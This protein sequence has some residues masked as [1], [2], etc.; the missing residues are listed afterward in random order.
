[1]TAPPGRHDLEADITF[2]AT[3]AGGKS[4]AARSGYRPGNDFGLRGMHNDAH[5]EFVEVDAVAPGQT[6]RARLWLLAPEYQA[7]RLHPGFE[8][9]VHE[10]TRLVARGVIVEVVNPSLRADT[11]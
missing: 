1:M 3:E 5:Y 2:L 6:A 7:G 8:F 9:T 10:G 4:N 11:R